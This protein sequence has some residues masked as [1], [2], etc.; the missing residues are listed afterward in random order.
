[1]QRLIEDSAL[2]FRKECEADAVGIW[3]V[4]KAAAASG[5][6]VEIASVAVEIVRLVMADGAV[7][8]GQFNNGQFVP[9]N[10]EPEEQ[11]HRLESEI[12]LRE[13]RVDIGEIGWLILN[14]RA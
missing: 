12:V 11:L 5:T 7:V 6:A 10:G 1:M 13:A 3:Q 14:A 9:W 4:V 2:R 8:L